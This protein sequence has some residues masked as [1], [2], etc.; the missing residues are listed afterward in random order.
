MTKQKE[1]Y[2]NLGLSEL[3]QLQRVSA[4]AWV[5]YIFFKRNI[6]FSTGES[7]KTSSLSEMGRLWTRP[8]KQGRAADAVRLERVRT[9][10][11]E[12]T[13]CGLVNFDYQTKKFSLP[14][15][16]KTPIEKSDALKPVPMSVGKSVPPRTAANPINTT[17]AKNIVYES[18]VNIAESAH[19]N[20]PEVLNQS[21]I[22]SFADGKPKESFIVWIQEKLN[23][24]KFLF[25]SN[26]KSE[27]YYDYW[28][29]LFDAGK[30]DK[31]KFE[32][33]LCSLLSNTTDVLTPMLLN[34]SIQENQNLTNPE[35]TTQRRGFA[36]M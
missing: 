20:T 32:T 30:L 5:A 1:F 15:H 25:V 18:V 3:K 21:Q 19:P 13:N 17:V 22:H 12:L 23:E 16:D 10:I 9:I 26:P 29:R 11:S 24:S 31:P 27:G 28:K 35:Q 4:L 36:W 33:I 14:K 34:K 7:S 8:A 2:I 6:D